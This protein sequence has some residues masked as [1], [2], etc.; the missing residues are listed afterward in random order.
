MPLRPNRFTPA[1]EIQP[2]MEDAAY[3]RAAALHI[4]LAA[5]L[6][7]RNR[8]L[9]ILA[10][11]VEL[12]VNPRKT[13]LLDRLAKLRAM[14][15]ATPPLSVSPDGLP[16]S[17]T[18]GLAAAQGAEWKE[19]PDRATKLKRLHAEKETLENAIG[20]VGGMMDDARAE[21]SRRA[22][23]AVLDRH[24][25]LQRRVH[26][27]ALA[28]A[29]ANNA[30]RDLFVSLLA[31]GYDGRPDILR[32]PGLMAAAVLGSPADNDSEISRF[33]RRLEEHGV[34]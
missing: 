24:R 22:A 26:D 5:A 15:P 23:E 16:P 12:N 20:A 6:A 9:E 17:V 34:I 2:L 10:L 1:D 13:V 25:T 11:E 21:A 32:R 28:F 7:E 14:T 31:A 8:G 3:S 30:E 4:T 27:C 18:N 19:K 33:R 29:A